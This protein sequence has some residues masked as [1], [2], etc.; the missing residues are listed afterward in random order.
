MKQAQ[1]SREQAPRR[2]DPSVH[3]FRAEALEVL[4]SRRILRKG[5]CEHFARISI[6]FRLQEALPSSVREPDRHQ[7]ELMGVLA[8]RS[9]E[10]VGVKAPRSTFSMR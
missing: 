7:Q 4:F 3:P 5:D 10:R 9:P 2:G 6:S 8:A 1:W